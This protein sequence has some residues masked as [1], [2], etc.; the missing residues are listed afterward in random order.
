MSS[1]E[2]RASKP[3]PYVLTSLSAPVGVIDAGTKARLDD[4]SKKMRG[5]HA[6]RGEL[7]KVLVWYAFWGI[8]ASLC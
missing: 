6:L 4:F 5:E 2:A 3:Q 8:G 7:A 1:D